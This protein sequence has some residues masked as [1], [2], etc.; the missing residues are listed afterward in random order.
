MRTIYDIYRD[1]N[2]WEYYIVV[3]EN[4]STK[5]LVDNDEEF[6]DAKYQYQIVN[7]EQYID[8]LIGWISECGRDSRGESN[9]KLMKQDLEYLMKL[10]DEFI[11][12]SLETNDFVAK[13]DDL[14]TF[15]NI[16]KDFIK[17]KS[18]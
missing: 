15:D 18:K 3:D 16:C 12:S 17:N 14:E 7:R 8:D 1:V 4:F 9:K 10:E 2:N 11:F 6:P 13:S 5:V